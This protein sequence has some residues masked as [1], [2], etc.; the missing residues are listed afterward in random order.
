MQISV[1]MAAPAADP[2]RIMNALKIHGFTVHLA[3]SSV[4]RTWLQDPTVR[5]KF[6]MKYSALDRCFQGL[7]LSFPLLVYPTILSA[8]YT[9]SQTLTVIDHIPLNDVPFNT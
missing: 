2:V 8:M 6:V 4:L 3:T 9:L 5:V 7:S 1:Q